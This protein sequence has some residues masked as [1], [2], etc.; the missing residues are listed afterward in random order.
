MLCMMN[1]GCATVWRDFVATKL[2]ICL[3]LKMIGKMLNRE[4]FLAFR[5][6]FVLL[7]PKNNNLLIL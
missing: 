3:R 6:F 7:H 5:N 2:K 4:D 1:I